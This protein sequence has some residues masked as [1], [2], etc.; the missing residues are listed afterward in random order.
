MVIQPVESAQE[1]FSRLASGDNRPAGGDAF[2]RIFAA[3]VDKGNS[4]D[5]QTGKVAEAAEI[6]RLEMMRGAVSISGAD[7]EPATPNISNALKAFLTNFAEESQKTDTAVS[8]LPPPME[9]KDAPTIRQ[10]TSPADFSPLSGPP[11]TRF[12]AIIKTA[13]MR[14]G[15]QEGLIKAVIK[16]ESNFNPKAVS[17][18]GARGLM[19]LMP[20][21]AAG[22]GV[23]DSFDPEQNIMAGT[24]FLRELLE[25]Y[26]G[27]LDSTL[28][29]YNWGPGNVDKSRGAFLPRETKEYL[30]K[31]KKYYSQYVG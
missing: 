2:A 17:H 14:Y 23:K 19:Q 13:A 15:V 27:D 9:T 18:A 31:V 16:M 25:K 7:P 22:L 3:S 30:V 21:T 28:A 4:A 8:I 5:G 11:A 20:S 1:R 26:G 12:D 29:A 24:R 6:L 10:T